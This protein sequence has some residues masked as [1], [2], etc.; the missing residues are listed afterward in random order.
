MVYPCSPFDNLFGLW[1]LWDKFLNLQSCTLM[2]FMG[3]NRNKSY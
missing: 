1:L 3:Y 2:N